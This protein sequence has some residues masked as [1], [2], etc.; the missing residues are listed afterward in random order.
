MRETEAARAARAKLAA[1][2]RAREADEARAAREEARIERDRLCDEARGAEAEAKERARAGLL[3]PAARSHAVRRASQGL[4]LGNVAEASEQAAARA[5][6]A[7]AAALEANQ[8]ERQ[9]ANL[10][11]RPKL[12]G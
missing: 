4:G 3:S 2:L 10:V 6:K 11:V 9:K 5:A 7:R 12:V 1:E 8:A